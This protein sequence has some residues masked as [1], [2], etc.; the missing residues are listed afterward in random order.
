MR[1]I[2]KIYTLNDTDC[3]QAS[4]LKI[5]LE[6]NTDY[7]TLLIHVFHFRLNVNTSAKVLLIKKSSERLMIFINY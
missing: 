2:D 5:I 4:G 3:L 1:K 6:E 7:A